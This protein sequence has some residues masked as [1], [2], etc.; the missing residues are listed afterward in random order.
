M[1]WLFF[2]LGFVAYC[3]A[4][5]IR[6]AWF[7]TSAWDLAIF[8]Q[9][10]FLIGQGLPAQS[11]LLG[12][13][14]LGDH[15]ALVLYPLGW[16]SRLIPSPSL[17][18][19]VQSAALAS[20]V[21]PLAEL[22]R[23]RGL[24]RGAIAASLAAILLY[25]VVFNSA[26]FDFHPETLAFPL[27][28]QVL[29]FLERSKPRDGWR[30]FG[31]L[32]LAL[33][34][35]L[36]LALLVLG[37]GF[38]VFVQGRRV[39]G[40][41]IAALGII[42]F[43]VISFWL[44]PHFGGGE[45]QL[46]RHGSKFGVKALAASASEMAWIGVVRQLLT[47]IFSLSSVEYLVLLM[48]PVLYVL[49]HRQVGRLFSGLIPFVPLLLLN[50]AASRP[51]LKDLVHHYSLFL[52]PFLISG[53]QQT[54]APGRLGLDGYPRWFGLRAPWVVMGWSVLAFIVF[55]RLGFY[56]GPFQ[57][58]FAHAAQLREAMAMVRPESSLLVSNSL[59]P[60]LAHRSILSITSPKEVERLNR[61]D[62]ILLDS[63][64][65]GFKSSPPLVKKM[66]GVIVADP[67]W[68]IDF[69]QN[70]VWLFSRQAAPREDAPADP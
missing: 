16:M 67:A 39:F 25:P 56:F 19:V 18:F 64:H 2:I 52:V 62:Q 22:A 15:G 11:S 43:F 63:S 29:C 45:A 17:L 61:Y 65:P 49:L 68:R 12:Y 48:L 59:A 8:D 26:I 7:Q 1:T 58:H 20:S 27:V 66:R 13:H 6:H 9:A 35:K 14:I 3:G 10:V 38:W 40:G 28:V 4:L 31:L 30:V 37:L 34:C 46:L 36:G 21:F 55:S 50:L 44:I 51:S 41:A 47:Q 57:E 42:W 69:E 53:V 60:H 33:T 54:L 23:L 70:G 32:V 5:A 24:S